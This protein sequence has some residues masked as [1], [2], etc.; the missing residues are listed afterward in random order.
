MLDALRAVRVVDPLEPDVGAEVR[1]DV[2]AAQDRVD[3]RDIAGDADGTVDQPDIDAVDLHLVVARL[4]RLGQAAGVELG[5]GQGL[6]ECCL[7]LRRVDADGEFL[8]ARDKA[9]EPADVGARARIDGDGQ[10]ARMHPRGHVVDAERDLRRL[11]RRPNRDV[12]AR[13]E[14]LEEEVGNRRGD[15]FGRRHLNVADADLVRHGERLVADALR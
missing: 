6:A 3:H 8:P 1:I 11:D 2:D 14:L 4:D 13:P 10:K 7:H 5:I 15:L 9:R 12:A